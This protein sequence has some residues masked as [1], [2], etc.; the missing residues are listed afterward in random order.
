MRLL[1][2]SLAITYNAPWPWLR[3]ITKTYSFFATVLNTYV[4]HE[5]IFYYFFFGW[6]GCGSWNDLQWWIQT[7]YNTPHNRLYYTHKFMA[8]RPQS[9]I[10]DAPRLLVLRCFLS[11]SLVS[12]YLAKTL[13]LT[14]VDFT[15][16]PHESVLSPLTLE[17]AGFGQHHQHM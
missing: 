7:L 17:V 8:R 4:R 1:V 14:N 2:Y 3:M 10:G 16:M 15:S 5:V 13:A 12:K 9:A 11:F 6:R